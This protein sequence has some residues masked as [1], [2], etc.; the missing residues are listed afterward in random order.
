LRYGHDLLKAAGR[1]T[2]VDTAADDVDERMGHRGRGSCDRAQPSIERLASLTAGRVPEGLR[3]GERDVG[4]K[5][6]VMGTT[7]D[8]E[9]EVL[10]VYE[11]RCLERAA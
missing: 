1:V 2:G 5:S 4:S 10:L 6:G 3:E 11:R 8:R 9:V 7:F